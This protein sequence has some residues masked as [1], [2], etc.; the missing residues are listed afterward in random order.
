MITN[1]KAVKKQAD[2]LNGEGTILGLF[3][4]GPNLS[5]G[6]YL[7]DGSGTVYYSTTRELLK[8]FL[9]SEISL[10]QLYLASHD[11]LVTKDSNGDMTSHPKQ[12]LEDLIFC[13]DKL[14]S[15]NAQSMRD[16]NFEE[17]FLK[18]LG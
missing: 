11:V 17:S 18:N 13:G 12:D 6:S 4:T 8:K 2:I 14:Y 16:A 15:E 10:K 3:N 1:V 9:T 7:K 5:L